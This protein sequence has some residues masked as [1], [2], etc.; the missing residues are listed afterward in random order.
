MAIPNEDYDFYKSVSKTNPK[1][2]KNQQSGGRKI[3]TID[4]QSQTETATEKWGLYGKA[5]GVK[6][7]EFKTRLYGTTELMTLTGVFWF[8]DGEF[9]YS[10]SDKSF[11]ISSKGK[12]VID[13]DIEKKLLTS[14]K[15]KCLS[16]LGFN[17]D[18]FLGMFD[19]AN[20]VNEMWGEFTLIDENQRQELSVMIQNSQTDLAKF[21]ESFGISKLSELPIKEYQKAKAM[22]QAKLNKV[23][24][25]A[26]NNPS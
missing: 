15:S 16:L 24:S 1:F 11:Y 19:D 4:P 14:F 26:T 6:D 2:V 23:K 10:V 9:P 12:D 3:S 22:L 20:Y 17:S 13:V 18:I 25:N 8:P 5:W 21:N 7:I